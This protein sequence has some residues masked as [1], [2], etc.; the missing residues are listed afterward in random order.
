MYEKYG[1]AIAMVAVIGIALNCSPNNVRRQVEPVPENAMAS[2]S[3]VETSA[4]LPAVAA[5][6]LI[7]RT[8]ITSDVNLLGVHDIR[9]C[10]NGIYST[11]MIRRDST[12]RF[13]DSALIVFITPMQGDVDCNNRT[14]VAD[15][16]KLVQMLFNVTL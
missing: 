15:L 5:R 11:W 14:N 4:A 10:G 2:R 3:V 13:I 12:G 8:A 7:Y 16:T 6:P 1:L 9:Y